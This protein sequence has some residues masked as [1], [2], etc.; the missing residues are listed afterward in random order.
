MP[1]VTGAAGMREGDVAA[2][3]ATGLHHLR[4]DAGYAVF[5]AGA[6]SYRFRSTL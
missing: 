4:D 6:G 1:C 3:A 5:A 2:S